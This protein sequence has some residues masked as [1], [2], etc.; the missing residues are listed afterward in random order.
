MPAVTF[1]GVVVERNKTSELSWVLGKCTHQCDETQG[2][3]R[4]Q[5]QALS[6]KVV[7]FG[8]KKIGNKTKKEAKK[9]TDKELM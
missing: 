1:D 8:C 3:N 6:T 4:T 9:R 5:S 2:N 7:F